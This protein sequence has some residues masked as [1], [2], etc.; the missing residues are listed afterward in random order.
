[1]AG[2]IGRAAVADVES[3]SATEFL[4]LRSSIAS[5]RR[6]LDVLDHRVLGVGARKD[7]HR[8]AGASSIDE[9][10]A[11]TGGVSRR[12]ANKTVRLAQ[13]LEKSPVLAEQMKQ[14]GMS[15]AKA[16]LITQAV[17]K[18]PTDFTAEQKQHIENELAIA[19]PAMS[20]EQFTRKTR[21]A[22][23]IVDPALANTREN[24]ELVRNESAAVRQATFWMTRP[25]E[26]GMVKG[27][28]EID[29]LTAD[30]LRS[31]LDSKTA[32]RYRAIQQRNGLTEASD[33]SGNTS[34]ELPGKPSGNQAGDPSATKFT[35]TQGEAFTDLLR[36]LP[37]DAY[38]NH[39]GVAA[40][41]MI[42]I[43]EDSLRNRT[44]TAGITEHGN[45]VS[46]GQL[47]HLACTTR[48]LPAVLGSKS[49]ILDLGREQRLHTS[50][51]R[52]TLAHRDKGCA[53]PG[54]ER[55]PGWCE[56]H[57]ITS[58]ANGG[59]TTIENGVL[60]CGYHHR[61]IHNSNWR[62][63]TNPRD[64]HPDFYPPGKSVPI[65]NTRYQPLVA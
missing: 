24:D 27:G 3:L 59:D 49:Q 28:F 65:R 1:M 12:E 30:M 29:A 23:E 62:I 44:D 43:S 39:G 51:Q 18:L 9:L 50:A 55:P 47:R 37:R 54:C 64:K 7:L 36:H 25:N 6:H 32:P 34:G 46:A 42:T 56:T 63:E 4:Q 21:R 40:T 33:Q 10:V 16:H 11:T 58:W 13:H 52:K 15:P 38:G 45:P 5:I 60:L 19:A 61:H 2:S 17:A 26:A 41:L 22:I 35:E 20:I 48:I 8:T 57:H 31:I 14:A 53:F